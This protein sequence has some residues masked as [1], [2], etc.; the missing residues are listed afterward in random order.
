MP[1]ATDSAAAPDPQGS[2]RLPERVA[3]IVPAKDEAERLGAT[4]E[5]LSRVEA[6]DLVV[7]VDDGSSDETLAVARQHGAETVRHEANMGKAQAMTSGAEVVRRLE[8]EDG[9]RGTEV[10]RALL[11]VDADLEASAANLGV[12]CV[13]VLAGEADMAIATLPPQKTAGGGFG[14]VVQKARY[15]IAELAGRTMRQP[16]SGMRCIT[17]E[18]FDAVLPLA[19]GWGVEVGLTV[20]VLRNRGRVVEVPVELHHRVTG[21]GPKAQL[22]RMRQYR[23]VARAL[24][25][26]ERR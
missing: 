13:P 14:F 2:G 5:A 16:L 10:P 1:G 21:R 6:V 12:L 3:A 20:D 22:H 23:D 19:R 18:A 24:K 7:V 15:G 4:L 8:A 26:R 25:V 17:R 11:F 9:P